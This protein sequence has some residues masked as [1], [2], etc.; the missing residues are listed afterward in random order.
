MNDRQAATCT[1]VSPVTQLARLTCVTVNR[2]ASGSVSHSQNARGYII[3]TTYSRCNDRQR[4]LIMSFHF[5]SRK[6][7][8]EQVNCKSMVYAD[9]SRLA[10][11]PWKLAVKR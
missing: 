6:Q 8:R 11:V 9:I 4:R 7:L 10:G 2:S 5:Y 3:I 1:A